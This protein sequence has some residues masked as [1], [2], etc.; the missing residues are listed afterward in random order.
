MAR[1][2]SSFNADGATCLFFQQ[3]T[4][5]FLFCGIGRYLKGAI[6]M[7]V[8][9]VSSNSSYT[10]SEAEESSNDISFNPAKLDP[11]NAGVNVKTHKITA[12]SGK[13]SERENRLGRQQPSAFPSSVVVHK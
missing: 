9:S 5:T 7:A 11:K 13:G 3:N 2:V 8:A 12:R 6:N 1:F 10:E 4:I